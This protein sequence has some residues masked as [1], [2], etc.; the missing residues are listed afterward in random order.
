MLLLGAN[1]HRHQ[2]AQLQPLGPDAR[3]RSHRRRAPDT[4][5]ITTSFTVPP[6]SFLIALKS[7]SRLLTQW[8]LRCG[9]ISTLSGVLARG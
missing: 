5:A 8:T 3:E 1:R 6:S 2:R 9:P 7:S 4:T